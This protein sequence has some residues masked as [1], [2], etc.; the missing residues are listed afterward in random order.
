MQFTAQDIYVHYDS[1]GVLI[2]GFSSGFNEQE[3]KKYFMIQDALEY[4]RQDIQLGTD[5][6]YIELNNQAKGLY[7]GVENLTIERDLISF[8]L[9]AAA[10]DRL[11]ET[12]IEIGLI[13]G[14]EEYKKLV[15]KLNLIFMCEEP[16][17]EETSEDSTLVG[18][19]F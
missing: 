9:N 15:E 3:D 17:Y 14:D 13:C 18:D 11:A 16:E 8:E 5:T 4:D 19:F 1:N 6:Y 2:V 7:G 10:Q 12:T